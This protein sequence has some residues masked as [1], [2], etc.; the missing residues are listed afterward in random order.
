MTMINKIE[1][2]TV[3]QNEVAM[4]LN[5]SYIIG[6][7]ARSLKVLKAF[8]A[9]SPEYSLSELSKKCNIDK[10]TMK[11]ILYTLQSEGFVKYNPLSR[12]YSLGFTMYRLGSTAFGIPE[13]KKMCFPILK[14]A[15][16][17][18]GQ[19]VHLAILAEDQVVVIDRFCADTH[20]DVM[21]LIA[22][23]GGSVPI[24]CTG[25]GAVLSA[26]ADDLTL[27]RMIKNCDF[28]KYTERTL[29][30]EYDFRQR[31]AVVKVNGFGINDGEHEEFLK[32]LTRPITDSSGNVIAAFSL[33]AL[34]ETMSEDKMNY[35]H[36]I[37]IE[38]QERLRR[39]F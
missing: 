24:H 30:N 6:S 28:R 11:R 33:S 39:E 32:C 18:T 27:D 31:L 1:F 21:T 14:D 25:V 13:L 23:I 10:A 2:H 20:I 5:N 29:T 36:K 12:Q 37:S 34:R 3:K 9:G 22:R 15:A 16:I 8:S 26:F 7:V 38:T 19:I 17:R 35:F 4:E